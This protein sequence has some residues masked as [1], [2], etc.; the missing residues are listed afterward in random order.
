[1]SEFFKSEMVRGELQEITELQQFCV[2]SVQTFPALSL[3]KRLD[4]FFKLK[5]LIEK[6]QIFWARLK[7]S[8]D[9]DAKMLLQN[10]AQASLMFGAEPNDDINQ[11][12]KS[13]LQKIDVMKSKAEADV[14]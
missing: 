13:L 5:T 10:L 12:F 14:G 1:M 3:D 8:D 9:P 6:L 4:Y 11:M 2:R 7:L